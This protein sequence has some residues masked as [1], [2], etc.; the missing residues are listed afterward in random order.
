M[1]RLDPFFFAY[2]RIALWNQFGHP[3]AT[4]LQGVRLNAWW[5]DPAKDKALAERKAGK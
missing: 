5:I 3:A 1:T 2:D 4:L